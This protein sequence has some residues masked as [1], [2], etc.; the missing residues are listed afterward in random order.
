QSPA[1]HPDGAAAVGSGRDVHRPAQYRR[2]HAPACFERSHINLGMHV[3][4]LEPGVG[5]QM[6]VDRLQRITGWVAVSSDAANSQLLALPDTGRDLQ[7]NHAAAAQH[8][9]PRAAL[10]AGA[11]FDSCTETVRTHAGSFDVD[12]GLTTIAGK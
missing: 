11:V 7:L 3:A 1:R 4:T 9:C 12:M 5:W 8:A 10:A 6:D 2:L